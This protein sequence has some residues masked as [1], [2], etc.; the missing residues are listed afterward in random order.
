MIF[1]TRHS[2]S[3][4]DRL[5][6]KS[7]RVEYQ[8]QGFHGNQAPNNR[9]IRSS[10]SR[11][12]RSC[13]KGYI[14]YK[15]FTCWQKHVQIAKRVLS[16]WPCWIYLPNLHALS[17]IRYIASIVISFVKCLLRVVSQPQP[18]WMPGNRSISYILEWWIGLLLPADLLHMHA[19][20]CKVVVLGR[21]VLN[22]DELMSNTRIESPSIFSFSPG[23]RVYSVCEIYYCASV[24]CVHILRW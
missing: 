4:A 14:F 18:V 22:F 3:V 19:A 16:S 15:C 2:H 1:H 6:S 8:L 10:N 21:S 5:S 17:Q 20:W 12:D 13:R 23:T 11:V 9:E 24:V 7:L